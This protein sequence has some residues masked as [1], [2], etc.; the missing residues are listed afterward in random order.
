MILINCFYIIQIM[1]IQIFYLLEIKYYQILI[2]QTFRKVSAKR[3]LLIFSTIC[4]KFLLYFL[5]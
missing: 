3:I 2:A 4:N 1:N 5:F